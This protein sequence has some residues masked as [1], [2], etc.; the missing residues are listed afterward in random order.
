MGKA[1]VSEPLLHMC[2]LYAC[3]TNPERSSI[4]ISALLTPCSTLQS[5]QYFWTR[6]GTRKGGQG[7]GPSAKR[8]D[9]AYNYKGL[10]HQIG[11]QSLRYNHE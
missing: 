2:S 7:R 6:Q 10:C 3:G 5:L 4:K 9:V 8:L 11:H 1:G